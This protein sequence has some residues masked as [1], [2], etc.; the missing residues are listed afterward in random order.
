MATPINYSTADLVFEISFAR[1]NRADAKMSFPKMG[2][3]SEQITDLITAGA[4]NGTLLHRFHSMFATASVEMWHR[5]IHSFMYSVALTKDSPLWSSVSGYYSSHYVMRAFAHSMGLYKSFIKREA[6]Q[7][8]P[9]GNQLGFTELSESGGEHAFYWKAVKQHPLF[10]RDPLFHQNIER[11]VNRRMDESDVLHRNFANYADHLDTFAPINFS[12]V[13][14][15]AKRVERI[16]HFRRNSVTAAA[17]QRDSF[18]DITNVQIL[19]FQR[20]VEFSDFL[21]KR[22]PDNR[23]WKTHRRPSWCRDIMLFKVESQGLEELEV[24]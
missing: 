13:E 1:L 4:A 12:S 19:A 9:N 18:P 6:L 3:L 14:G 7:I 15:V 22:I 5:A 10:I 21:D 2:S 20:I 24:A 8:V 16:S 17:P 23:F 11:D